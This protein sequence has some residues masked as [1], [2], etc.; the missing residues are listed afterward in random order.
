MV[1]VVVVLVAATDDDGIES[2]KNLPGNVL[3]GTLAE[4]LERVGT[5]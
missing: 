3:N 2:E 1:V 5:F 4:L